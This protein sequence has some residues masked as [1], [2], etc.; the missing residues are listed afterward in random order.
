MSGFYEYD[1]PVDKLDDDS[2][3]LFAIPRS[4]ILNKD[5]GEKRI[6]VFSFFSIARGIN[7]RLSFSV[8]EIV[9]WAG[10]KP[11]RNKNGINSKMFCS[12]GKL[13]DYGYIEIFDD[14]AGSH[15]AKA[16]LNGSYIQE[17][18]NECS[19]AILYADE[20]EKILGYDGFDSGDKL[21]NNDVVLLMFAYLRMAI[22]TRPNRLKPEELN[23]DGNDNRSHDIDKRRINRPEAYNDY[24]DNMAEEIGVSP[25]VASKAVDILV[26]LGLIYI[27]PL[28]RFKIEGKWN[29]DHTIF[30]NIYK[31]GEYNQRQYLLDEGEDYYLREIKN[32]KRIISN[33]KK[34]NRR[35]SKQGDD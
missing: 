27:E 29:T 4:I 20:V 11:N 21:L 24:Y 2:R 13:A 5:I 7:Y 15:R 25:R 28:P 31:R 16:K 12:V 30:C 9:E 10:R 23:C 34:Q 14:C 1:N 6:T 8:N 18:A 17:Q 35:Q 3:C 32:K 33:I 19:F 22:Y 26:E